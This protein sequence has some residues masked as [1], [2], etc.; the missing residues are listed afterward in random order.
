MPQD[1][2]VTV[3]LPESL[4]RQFTDL[5]NRLFSL[6]S[7]FAVS[8]G[9]S[10]ILLSLLIVIIS[11]RLWDT[12]VWIRVTIFGAGILSA[13]VVLLWWLRLWVFRP[14]DLRALAVLVQRKYR[15]LGDRLLGIV[16]LS[17]EASRP[18]YFSPEL[19]RAA[20]TQVTDEA[21]KYNF[22]DAANRTRTNRQL[23]A[24]AGLLVLVLLPALILPDATWNSFR[25]WIAPLARIPRF[26]LV[27]LAG[28]PQERIVAHG[29]KFA[30][31]GKVTYRS[32]WKP[33]RVQLQL[34]NGQ[35]LPA[36]AE[37]GQFT[38]EVPSQVQDAKGVVRAGDAEHQIT[39]R[40]HHRPAIQEA[41]A[42]IDLPEYLGY[43]P[44]KENA[45]SGLLEVLEGSSISVS[46]RLSRPLVSASLQA[47]DRN[48]RISP[49]SRIPSQLPGCR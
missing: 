42:Q 43:P 27:E 38:F 34:A 4:Q 48:F 28:M 37:N 17:D 30:F 40:A 49:S 6:E 36:R 23:L 9:T 20:I 7:L 11:D 47:A 31:S 41:T 35:R 8:A 29:E 33:A 14:R 19:Y 10:A 12:P 16:E 44:Q 13:L 18:A 25:R 15:R 22:S 26:T 3:S 21:V 5:R 32:F 46:A 2:K 1:E 24:S 39:F 45:Q